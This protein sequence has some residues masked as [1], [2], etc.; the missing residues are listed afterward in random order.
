MKAVQI[1]NGAS[2]LQIFT[3]PSF[4]GTE[5]NYLRAQIARITAATQISPIGFYRFGEGGGDEEEEEEVP[6]EEEDAGKY[7]AAF[8]PNRFL[9]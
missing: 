8:R 5:K 6:E 7:Q 1:I 3:Y 9:T 2:V 4:P